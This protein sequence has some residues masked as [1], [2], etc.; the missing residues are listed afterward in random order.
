MTQ[1]P[2]E[3]DKAAWSWAKAKRE[4]AQARDRRLEAEARILELVGCKDE[5]VTKTE[6][7]YYTVRTEGSITRTL[8]DDFAKRMDSLAPE[9]FNQ[10]IKWRPTIDVRAL[11]ALATSNPE[12][13][14]QVCAGIISKE[15]KPAVKV[16]DR[17]MQQ[18]AA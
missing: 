9:I 1:E 10:V 17:Q 15:A 6:T 11:K 13:Y 16:E 14:R 4:E 5:G 7:A 18:E 8:T 3:L 12:A 2:T